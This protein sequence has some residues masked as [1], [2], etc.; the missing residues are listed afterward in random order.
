MEELESWVSDWSNDKKEMPLFFEI[1]LKE[2]EKGVKGPTAALILD[3][4]ELERSNSFWEKIRS[5]HE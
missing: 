5:F 3:N 4:W 1:S 2:T